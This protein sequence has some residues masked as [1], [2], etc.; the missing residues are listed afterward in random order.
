MVFEVERLAGDGGRP[1]STTVRERLKLQG[2]A[3]RLEAL[4]EKTGLKLV[5]LNDKADQLQSLKDAAFAEEL[6]RR[7]KRRQLKQE[8]RQREAQAAGGEAAAVAGDDGDDGTTRTLTCHRGSNGGHAPLS[9]WT[10]CWLLEQEL[11]QNQVPDLAALA[12]RL[13]RDPDEMILKAEELKHNFRRDW[14]G[15][16]VPAW[17]QPATGPL[18]SLQAL[19]HQVRVPA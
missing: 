3:M 9:G 13:G 4:I 14:V 2:L 8:K 1:K 11:R 16:P 12:A 17:A 10:R 7:E 19:M 5:D 15:K 6:A 18:P